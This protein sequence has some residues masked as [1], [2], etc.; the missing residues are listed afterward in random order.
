VLRR[1]HYGDK[2]LTSS[3]TKTS[4]AAREEKGF[5]QDMGQRIAR[6]RKEQGLTQAQL[7]ETLGVAQQTMAH[8][9]VGRLRVAVAMVP[10]LART[11]AVPIDELLEGPAVSK[12]KRRPA[13]KLQRQLA[14]ITQLPKAKQRSVT[15]LLDTVI[16]DP[17]S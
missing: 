7:A 15:E 3:A 2:P 9:E 12:G 17:T 11:L 14:H 13:P 5:Y 16:E 6:L 8:Y 4:A 1:C 10:V